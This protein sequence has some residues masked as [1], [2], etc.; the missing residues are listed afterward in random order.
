MIVLNANNNK[1][2]KSGRTSCKAR[3]ALFRFEKS[4][5]FLIST[6]SHPVLHYIAFTA[7][8]VR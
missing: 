1:Y 4:A 6:G 3:T 5:E 8:S 2:V 7:S